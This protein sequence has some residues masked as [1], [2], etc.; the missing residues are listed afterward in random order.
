MS[1]LGLLQASLPGRLTL[2]VL[3]TLVELPG[4]SLPVTSSPT[5]SLY[6]ETLCQ[7]CEAKLDTCNSS[8]TGHV[9]CPCRIGGGTPRHLQQ[10]MSDAV[11]DAPTREEQVTAYLNR[12]ETF[13]SLV[14]DESRDTRVRMFA[15]LEQVV[16]F[17]SLAEERNM[18]LSGLRA[19]NIRLRSEVVALAEQV[20]ACWC[21]DVPP[22]V[23][24]RG[25]CRG[26]WDVGG[27][28]WGGLKRHRHGRY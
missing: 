8:D 5:L 18:H 25:C 13:R 15:A 22:A 3:A 16:R 23:G 24:G 14:T 10:Q 20:G 11:G 19:E 28:R 17:S 21:V 27:V 1:R 7:L 26:V 9:L 2:P 6:T 12:H 4:C